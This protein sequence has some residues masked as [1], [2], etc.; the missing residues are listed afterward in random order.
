VAHAEIGRRY[1]DRLPVQTTCGVIASPSGAAVR[2]PLLAAHRWRYRWLRNSIP[3]HAVRR[4][5]GGGS[6]VLDDIR[7]DIDEVIA[8]LAEALQVFN[9]D[10]RGALGQLGGAVELPRRGRP[11]VFEAGG[12]DELETVLAAR[13]TDAP[14]LVTN[15]TADHLGRLAPLLTGVEQVVGYHE[16]LGCWLLLGCPASALPASWQSHRATP[17]GMRGLAT[18]H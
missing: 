17:L 13:R 6:V 10:E 5:I 8:G 2:P 14:T 18:T 3:A 9:L 12:L 4:A 15:L 11:V 7:L 16:A 1:P